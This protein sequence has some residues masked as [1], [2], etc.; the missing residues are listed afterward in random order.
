VHTIG[1]GSGA[2]K[3]LIIESAKKGRGHHLFIN[4]RD[5]VSGAI[6]LLLEKAL[7]P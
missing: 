4:D 5:D 1:I 6:I 3:Y 2:S 7:T